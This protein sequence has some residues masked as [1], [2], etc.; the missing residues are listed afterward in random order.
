MRTNITAGHPLSAITGGLIVVAVAALQ[1]II[2]PGNAAADP[3]CPV[4]GP[5]CPGLVWVRLLLV[6]C[7][8]LASASLGL[9]WFPIRSTSWIR[10]S[11]AAGCTAHPCDAARESVATKPIK[12]RQRGHQCPDAILGH[13]WIRG[14]QAADHL[15]DPA[16]HFAYHQ[17][18]NNRDRRSFPHRQRKNH[19][20]NVRKVAGVPTADEQHFRETIF[21]GQ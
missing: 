4:P 12:I 16:N 21:P 10:F 13:L 3:L 20:G 11:K 14:E 8:V 5:G 2:H 18:S 9:G 15:A 1:M 6:C 19:T 7:L 17:L